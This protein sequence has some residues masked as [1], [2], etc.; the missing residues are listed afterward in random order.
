MKVPELTYKQLAGWVTKQRQK[1]KEGKLP[2]DYQKKLEAIGFQW[3]VY[4][5]S[6]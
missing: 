6:Q 3:R 1:Y 2:K 5:T 4:K